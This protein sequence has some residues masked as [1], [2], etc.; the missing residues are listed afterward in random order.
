MAQPYT[1]DRVP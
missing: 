1:A